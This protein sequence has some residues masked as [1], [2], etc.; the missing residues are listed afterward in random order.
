VIAPQM[1]FS[2]V[3]QVFPAKLFNPFLSVAMHCTEFLT[4][5]RHRFT[6][7]SS[8]QGMG[9]QSSSRL[10]LTRLHYASRGHIY[11]LCTYYKNFIFQ[12][13]MYTTYCY[14]SHVQ[15]ANWPTITGLVLCH[16]K[17]CIKP[18]RDSWPSKRGKLL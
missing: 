12:A 17:F 1:L 15:H 10:Q 7:R 18:K 2:Y 6:I 4:C 8:M 3:T 16:V 5:C 9:L 14:F 13:V 11:K